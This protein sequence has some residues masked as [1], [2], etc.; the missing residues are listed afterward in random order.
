MMI[1]IQKRTIN[2]STIHIPLA[3]GLHGLDGDA[4]IVDGKTSPVQEEATKVGPKI[5]NTSDIYI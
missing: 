1:K 2:S 3:Q 4:D 5:C